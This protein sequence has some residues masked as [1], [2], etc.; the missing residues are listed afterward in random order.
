MNQR[1]CLSVLKY[2]FNT[3]NLA[4]PLGNRLIRL[5]ENTYEVDSLPFILFFLHHVDARMFKSCL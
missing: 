2:T 1:L 5:E 3:L 4:F